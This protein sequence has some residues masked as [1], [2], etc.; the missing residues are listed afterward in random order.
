MGA[1]AQQRTT[2]LAWSGQVLRAGHFRV[3]EV[4]VFAAAESL[5]VVVGEVP[6]PQK[7]QGEALWVYRIRPSAIDQLCR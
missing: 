7:V 4:A 2:Q 6:D 1:S 5:E 3:H